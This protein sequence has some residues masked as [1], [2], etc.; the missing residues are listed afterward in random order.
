M[1]LMIA[2]FGLKYLPASDILKAFD[3]AIH[4][5]VDV[6]TMSLAGRSQRS[7]FEDPFSVGSFHAYENG[8]LVVAFAGNNGLLGGATVP[9]VIKVAAVG[10]EF[11]TTTQLGNG[12]V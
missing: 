4:D 12:D 8:I 11:L 5:N 7:Y 10:Q 2:A 3:D 6:I 1:D 9:W